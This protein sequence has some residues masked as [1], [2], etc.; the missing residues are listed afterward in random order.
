MRML[1]YAFND[2]I[3]KDEDY[4]AVFASC[5]DKYEELIRDVIDTQNIKSYDPFYLRDRLPIDVLPFLYPKK[6]GVMTT[7]IPKD[8][9]VKLAFQTLFLFLLRPHVSLKC[10]NNSDFSQYWCLSNKPMCLLIRCRRGVFSSG[11]HRFS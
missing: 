6:I 7:E 10:K 8:D 9:E 5:V 2:E 3:M 11:L 4:L 1:I